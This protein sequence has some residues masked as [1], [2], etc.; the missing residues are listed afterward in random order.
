MWSFVPFQPEERIATGNQHIEE[1]SEPEEFV[2]AY[3]TASV[4]NAWHEGIK[5]GRSA[6]DLSRHPREPNKKGLKGIHGSKGLRAN[7]KYTTAG[8]EKMRGG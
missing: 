5:N 4:E 3:K 7:K 1:I 6:Q 8:K 2:E